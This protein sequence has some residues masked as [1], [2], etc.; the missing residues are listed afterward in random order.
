MYAGNTDLEF[1]ASNCTIGNDN[2]VIA[3]VGTVYTEIKCT[4]SAE[5]RV[6]TESVVI[7]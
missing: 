3:G 7:G 4:T 5:P 1:V 2:N 6:Q